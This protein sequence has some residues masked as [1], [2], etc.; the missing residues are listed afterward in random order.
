MSKLII[1]YLLWI[2]DNWDKKRK[3]N[4]HFIIGD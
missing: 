2:N 3:N 1:D 4:I